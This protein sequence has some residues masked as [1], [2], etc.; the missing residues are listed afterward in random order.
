MPVPLPAAPVGAQDAPSVV[1]S[2]WLLGALLCVLVLAAPFLGPWWAAALAAAAGLGATGA[3]ALR[4]GRAQA[5]AQAQADHVATG[6]ARTEGE[7]AAL[8]RALEALP[9]PTALCG[10]D[11]IVL[12]ASSSLT[13][14]GASGRTKGVPLEALVG[15]GAA[16]AASSDAQALAEV[17]TPGGAV[18]VL[19]RSAPAPGNMRV[20]QLLPPGADAAQASEADAHQ[21]ALRETSRTVGELAQRLASASELMSAY[22][23]DQAKGAA[24]QKEQTVAVT[25]SIERM[26]GAVMDIASNASGTSQAA[27]QARDVARDGVD[28]VHRAVQGVDA[29]AGSARELA[30]VLAGLD[31]QA[32]EIGRITGVITDIADQTN[33]LA[34][35]AAIEAARAGDAGRGF[36]VVADEVR[37]LAE[38]TVT[39]TQE[40]RQAITTIQQSSK[41]AVASMGRTGSQVAES[42]ELSTRAG[43]ALEQVMTGIEAVVDRVQQ[44]ARAAGE[45]SALAENISSSVEEIADIARDADEGATQQAYA[46]REIATLSADLL[47]VSRGGQGADQDAGPALVAGLPV[48]GA[49]PGLVRD[50]L[51]DTLGAEGLRAAQKEL[52]AAPGGEAPAALLRRMA[53]LGAARGGPAARQLL[54]QLGQRAAR[55]L[56]KR[57]P[58]LFKGRDLRAFLLT[59]ADI[60]AQGAAGSPGA[61]P[62]RITCEDKGAVLFMNYTAPQG[63]AE[64]FQG[65]VEGAAA[66]LGPGATVTARPLD[67]QT[68]RAEVRFAQPGR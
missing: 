13:A 52:D 14:L 55:D 15:P 8:H 18:A 63:L 59:L 37:K 60:H 1:P 64:V 5:R 39:A 41:D 42:T 12:A 54:R 29:L 34:L 21:D 2:I 30:E 26:M 22:A 49:L 44:I 23:D 53:D 50:L 47:R 24:R 3:V 68:A 25:D 28:L 11:M 43:Q 40:V 36:A 9:V 31:R 4:A 16:R 7:L 56:E 10:P 32:A 19:V 65:F 17:P 62:P 67:A 20:V 35:N 57:Q 46:T 48:P 66:L 27:D 38:K 33:L 6:L 45:Q 61:R 51:R 58:A